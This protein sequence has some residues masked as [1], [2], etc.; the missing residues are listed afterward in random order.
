MKRALML[1][2]CLLPMPLA[3]DELQVYESI[4]EIEIGRVFLKPAERTALDRR[5]E[6]PAQ[7]PS[8]VSRSATA[9]PPA[10]RAENRPAGYI[11]S[12]DGTRR[13]WR[14]GDFVADGRSAQ[15]RF[16]GD[17]RIERQEPP[18]SQDESDGHAED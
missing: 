14:S 12:S 10:R 15:M 13:H 11:E 16:P 4:D 17:I 18:E 5:R 1:L 2:A 6:L 3:A 7:A 8:S 9:A